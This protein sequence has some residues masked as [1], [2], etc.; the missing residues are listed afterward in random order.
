MSITKFLRLNSRGADRAMVQEVI[1]RPLTADTRFH[2][3]ATLYG[4]C[5]EKLLTECFGLHLPTIFQRCFTLVFS[6]LPA[7]VENMVSSK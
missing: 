2:F 7:Y 6:P 4:I 1:R 5:S 3:Q